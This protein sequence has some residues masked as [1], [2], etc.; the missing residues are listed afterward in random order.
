MLWACS[1]LVYEANLLDLVLCTQ[2]Y[3]RN[4]S[5]KHESSDYLKFMLRFICFMLIYRCFAQNMEWDMCKTFI[6]CTMSVLHH[7]C[8]CTTEYHTN[9]LSKH[10]K[11]WAHWVKLSL[12]IILF[13]PILECKTVVQSCTVSH[14]DQVVGMLENK[15]FMLNTSIHLQ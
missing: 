4:S 2:S 6:C 13:L 12:L 8:L 15:Y 7:G 11:K 14:R 10:W 9:H 5:Y 3:L 1:S